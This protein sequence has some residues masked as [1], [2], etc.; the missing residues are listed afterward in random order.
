M[1]HSRRHF[2]QYSA[3]LIATLGAAA[4]G[5]RYLHPPP[6][7]RVWRHGLALGH[8]IRDGLTLPAS[9]P[10]YR[11]P[12]LI[13][14][15][16]AAGLAAAWYLARSGQ[17]QFCLAQGIEADGNAAAAHYSGLA[18]PTGAHYLAPPAGN[19]A[20][21]HTLLR[22]LAI[23][24]EDGRYRETDLVYAPEARLWYQGRWQDGLLPEEDDDSRRFFAHIAQLKTA[25]GRDGLPAFAIPI[26]HASRDPQWLDLDKQ[27]FA[28]WLDAH[29]Y[30]S[31]TL[32]WYLDY[33]CRDDYG[34]DS[35]VVS[36][37]AGL[38]YF[39]GRGH[40]DETVLT[41]PQGLAHLCAGM[42]RH[43]ALQ[44]VPHWLSPPQ[45]ADASV[46][47]ASAVAIEER[48]D[49]VDIILRHN[50][51]GDFIRLQV[52]HLICAAP[53]YVVRR[54][55][56]RAETY[57]F[58]D[59]LP[60]YAPWLVANFL[61]HGN[62]PESNG[63]MPA[64]DNV[65]YGG[66]GLGYVHAGHQ[67]LAVAPSAY[68]VFTSYTA[69][70]HAAP[71]EVRRHL[72]HATDAE[73]L[74]LASQDLH[75]VYGDHFARRTVLADLHVRA[76]AMSIPSVGYRT[77]PLLQKL[78]NHRSRIVFAHSDLSGY[79]VF[80]EAVHWGVEAARAVLSGA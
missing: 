19:A 52:A 13:V 37:Y 78:Q 66:A 38:H 18:A 67:T 70:N 72:L 5:H 47:D 34:Q 55:L 21:I 75:A 40:N 49:G 77:A 68:R 6:E 4:A 33:C 73:L 3:A 46:L 29:R 31:P 12:I 53:L 15:S 9:M 16:G 22:D 41:W 27:T 24:G 60:D 30:T 39:A 74:Q 42:R 54:I 50:Q 14:G 65:V 17:R 20:H 1:S 44:R 63:Q 61:L 36:A 28:Q 56:R 69:L 43:A 23:L 10:T 8:R 26:A 64:W 58:R 48:D 11:C 80:E 35:R 25:R 32:R 45:N 51:Y 2:L 76:H 79:S 62:L 57:G 7:L 71:D 59:N